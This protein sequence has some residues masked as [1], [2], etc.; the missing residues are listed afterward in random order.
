M[1]ALQRY[2]NVGNSHIQLQHQRC[3][4]IY[5][6]QINQVLLEKERRDVKDRCALRLQIS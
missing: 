4:N 1:R 2:E 3:L 5:T 6:G